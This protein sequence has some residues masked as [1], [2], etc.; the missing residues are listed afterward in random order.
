MRS[1]I[2]ARGLT[3]RFGDVVAL[4]RVDLEVGEGSIYGLVG[5]NGA[6]KTTLI[7]TLVG[8]VKPDE[9]SVSVAGVDPS[10]DKRQVRSF[11][12][13]MPQ[14]SVLYSDLTARENV[15]FF[16]RG[17]SRGNADDAVE[18]ALD[19]ASLDQFANRQ[20][21][22]LSGGM[23]QRVSL[24]VAMAHSPNV[25]LLDE[26]TAGIDPE[27]RHVFWEGFRELAQSGVTL[28]ITTHQM[29]EVV[30]CDRVAL[31]RRGKVLA[32]ATPS[33]LL[34][35]G[36][37]L[38]RIGNGE[39]A[40]EQRVADVV[41]DLPRILHGNGLDPAIDRIEVRYSTLEEVILG[42][43]ERDGGSDSG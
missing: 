24:S 32:E 3:K 10:A 9:G 35:S 21:H 2:S 8:A 38:V 16:L 5:P 6:G 43:V 13:Y 29:D 4:D 7:R 33:D 39:G 12:G 27:L 31:L 15:A 25:L 19:F 36:G 34:A 40:A 20:V 23:Q 17:H 14:R 18:Q 37:A 41:V 42:L 1:A 11:V 22:T 28:F 26:P 30:H